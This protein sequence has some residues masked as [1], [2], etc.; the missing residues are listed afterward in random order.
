MKSRDIKMK[1]TEVFYAH[2]GNRYDT[3]KEVVLSN[4]QAP[5][6]IRGIVK[7]FVE[8]EA[9]DLLSKELTKAKQDLAD[10]VK[11]IESYKNVCGI[12]RRIALE[13]FLSKLKGSE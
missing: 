4:Q 5:I 6:A 12:S 7:E 8:K 3:S 1:T 11:V 9:Y 13:K 10:T 2:Y